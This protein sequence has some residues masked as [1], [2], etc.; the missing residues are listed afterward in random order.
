M[1]RLALNKSLF[2]FVDSPDDITIARFKLWA[3]NIAN[4]EDYHA[5]THKLKS[6]PIEKNTLL[7]ENGIDSLEKFNYAEFY[8]LYFN[9][10]FA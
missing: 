5:I 4:T 10:R 9:K 8:K 6:I 3:T 2:E 1:I 7:Q